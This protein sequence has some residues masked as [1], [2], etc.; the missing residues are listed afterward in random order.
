MEIK[1]QRWIWNKQLL[2]ALE[3]QNEGL[4]ILKYGETDYNVQIKYDYHIS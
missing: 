4:F 2:K 1:M 3:I